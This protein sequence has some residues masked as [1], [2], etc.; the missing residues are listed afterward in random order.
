[1]AEILT[2]NGAIVAGEPKVGSLVKLK[3]QQFSPKMTLISIQRGKV[4][5]TNRAITIAQCGWFEQGFQSMHGMSC[6]VA[7]LEICN[8]TN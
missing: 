7:A 3:G 5:E 8:D 2:T 6:E 4:P 1:M